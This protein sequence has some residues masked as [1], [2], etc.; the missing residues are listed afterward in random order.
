MVKAWESNITFYGNKVE[1]DSEPRVCREADRLVYGARG[2]DYG[3]PLD[4]YER[5]AQIANALVGHKLK[6]PLTAEDMIR[7]MIGVKLSRDVHR[8]KRDNR[9]DMAGYAECL[10]RASV[11]RERRAQ[12]ITNDTPHAVNAPQRIVSDQNPEPTSRDQFY[13]ARAARMDG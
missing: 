11:E 10:E 6:E 4:D 2:V 7:M 9:V 5:T 12:P 8:P 3:H 1:N 13:A